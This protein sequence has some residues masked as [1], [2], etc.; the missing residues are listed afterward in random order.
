L[1]GSFFG[2]N[3]AARG[4]TTAQRNL[5]VV[6]HNLSNV[7][8]PGFTR[9]KAKQVA[10]NP[11][12]SFDRTGM[13]GTGSEVALIQRVRDEYLDYKF[14]SESVFFGEWDAK[15]ILLSD[16]EA[17]FNEP[18]DG[19]F[20][21]ILN[22]YFN[23][24]QELSK[25]PSAPATRAL[26]KEKGVAVARYFNNLALRFEKLQHDIN[27][28]V[29]VKVD[30][31]NSYA[32]Q[33]SQL[34]KQ[35]YTLEVDGSHANDLRD[36]R[37]Y[38]VDNLSKLVNIEANEIVVGKLPGGRD[39]KH[40]VVSVGGKPIVNHFEL[41]KLTVHPR[42]SKVNE[43][44]IENLYH[45]TWEDGSKVNINSGELKGYL[46]V[47]DGNSGINGSPSFKGIP[48]YINKLNNFV[49][50]FAMALNEGYCDNNSNGSIEPEEDFFGHADG[51]SLN[52]AEG[53]PPSGVRFFTM[54][55]DDGNPLNSNDFIFGA[56][57]IAEIE[58]K[59]KS[60]TARNFCVSADIIADI[61]LISTSDQPEQKGN[62]NVLT[63]MLKMRNNSH[64]FS[65][66]SP[67][68]YMKSLVATLGVDSQQ[69][70]KYYDNLN[71]IVK[72]IDNRRL[73]ISGVSVDEEMAGMI[74]FQHAYM[75]AAKMINLMDE[76]YD[77]LINR[78]GI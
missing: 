61:N 12:L 9:Q 44:D 58:S 74:K 52:S 37:E 7:N 11:L 18:S 57:T 77:V 46:D 15:R 62:I 55:G 42:D 19:G 64:M 66:G 36:R 71:T 8:T 65:E 14:W 30:Q 50:T 38:L 21:K 49:R 17:A 5:D 27:Q 23:A 31:L 53:D 59:Y 10:S 3:I 4:L 78:V 33:I 51:Y 39:D 56:G 69:A 24:M 68:D 60:I 54:T 34:N 41:T 43:E 70:V 26:I 20:T 16:V 63:S 72:Q 22:E 25:D 40:F 13:I 29:S 2:L 67:E 76:L 75:A 47:R 1:Q 35:I 48:H 45:I 6:S 32:T 73:S 28:N